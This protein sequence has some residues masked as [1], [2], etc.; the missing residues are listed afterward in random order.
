MATDDEVTREQVTTAERA[1][2]H[3]S[4]PEMPAASGAA[5]YR[6]GAAIGAGGM[7]EV[8]AARDEQLGR[9]V[10]IKRLRAREPSER[11]VTRF[12]HEARIQGRLDHPAIVPVHEL[13]QDADGLPF[14]AMKKLAGTTLHEVLAGGAA[15]PRLLRAFADVCLA[16]EFAHVHGVIH[17]DIKPENIVLGD[18][19]DVYVLDWGVAK[20]IGDD[21]TDDFDDLRGPGTHA[22]ATI[23][24]PSYMAP[25]QI[26][27]ASNVDAR[28]DV[29]ALGKVLAKILAHEPDAPPEL[30][31]LAGAAIARD[32]DERIGTA[33]ELAV[34]IQAYLDGDRDLAL[35]RKLARE[36]HAHA[37]AAFA[38]GLSDADRG[39]AI[40]AAS[41]AMALDPT[42]AGAAELVG[43]L[44][45]EPPREVPPAV[46]AAAVA[47]E[48]GWVYEQGVAA[49]KVNLIGLAIAVPALAALGSP[50]GAAIYAAFALLAFAA[51]S[52][53]LRE[54]ATFR[55]LPSI[56]HAT[57]MAIGVAILAHEFGPTTV[58][59]PIVAIMAA[60]LAA[61]PLLERRHAVLIGLV[62]VMGALGPLLAEQVGLLSRTISVD[63]DASYGFSPARCKSIALLVPSI[64]LLVASTVVLAMLIGRSMRGRERRLRRQLH[65]QAWQLRQLV[66]G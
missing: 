31:A 10:A 27:D 61:N 50:F 56:V 4:H 57:V 3:G 48:V 28:T 51:N 38:A 58:A 42:L 40:R 19:G 49:N 18:F 13:G 55:P 20:V 44:M 34:Q 35:R 33:R 7:G 60:A 21:R 53:V 9:E 63:A 45:L 36:H 32:R 47:D 37:R 39:V 65:M 41:S 16:I 64:L 24:T 12:L 14:F 22:G 5:R 1:G 2:G 23:G 59:P 26:E 62:L 11:Q 25:E 17:R 15:R 66:T 8:L 43:R 54:R 52:Y 29:F 6:L 30:L 46:E